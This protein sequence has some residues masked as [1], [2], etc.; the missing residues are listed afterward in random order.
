MIDLEHPVPVLPP[1]W[2]ST[3]AYAL[4]SVTLIMVQS[5]KAQLYMFNFW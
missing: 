3:L 4:E 2:Q 5:L 1:F